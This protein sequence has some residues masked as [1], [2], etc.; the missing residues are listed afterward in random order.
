MRE[1][2]LA[3]KGMDMIKSL[4]IYPSQ[5]V[6]AGVLSFFF[7]IGGVKSGA[8]VALNA[9][10]LIL[11]AFLMDRVVR[12]VAGSACGIIAAMCTLFIPS[13]SFVV[14]TY[15]S[16]VF[17][18]AVLLLNIDLWL[19]LLNAGD[20]L[21][22]KKQMIL[23]GVFGL[24]LALLCYIEPLM[25]LCTAAFIVY[26]AVRQKN[27]DK[28]PRVRTIIM[29]AA[30]VVFL[31]LLLFL[32]SVSLGSDFGSVI[33][34]SMSRYKLGTDIETSEKY[35]AGQVFEKFHENLDNQNTNVTDNYHFLVNDEGESYTQTHNAWFSLGTQMSY[36]FAL[37]MSIACSYYM[38]RNKTEKAI[39][40][41]IILAVS[42]LA[43][44]FRSTDEASTF[45][46]FELLIITACCGLN[47]MYMNHHP[48][49]FAHALGEEADTVRVED[50]S[51]IGGAME[52]GAIAKARKLIFVKNEDE[53]KEIPQKT[54][55]L[56]N[57]YVAEQEEENPVSDDMS[58]S[59]SDGGYVQ[60]SVSPEG[61]FSF[62]DMSPSPAPARKSAPVP[63]PEPEPEPVDEY[64]GPIEE[65]AEDEMESFAGAYEARS[66]EDDSYEEPSYEEES[67]D[68]PYE[69]TEEE[70]EEIYDPSY[71]GSYDEPSFDELAGEYGGD[72]NE[73]SE[74][75]AYPEG[76]Y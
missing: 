9:I 35:T 55:P 29:C 24:T 46:M 15:G 51:S 23:S 38:F 31:L 5:C 19:I 73:G 52:W 53:S 44:F 6:Y 60:G 40:L 34:G 10:T 74:G 41:F 68:A 25:L 20:E 49:I 22:D 47:Y 71:E 7:R 27:E 3:D 66:Y 43:L 8:M 54:E 76:E 32:K 16:E 56:E 18:C 14:Y 30:A 33:S 61:Y 28:E 62:F 26:Y 58:V 11:T 17:F 2:A 39:P 4:I 21:D 12:K 63:A 42:F 13:Q 36:M 1:G 45:F 75:E 69:G 48:E 67:Y 65:I 57:T 50:S 64:D 37:V 72:Y 59:A 70:Y